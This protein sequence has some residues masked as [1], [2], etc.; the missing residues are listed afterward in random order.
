MTEADAMHFIASAKSTDQLYSRSLPDAPIHY[1]VG[2][3]GAGG[4]GLVINGELMFETRC[5]VGPD[6]VQEDAQNCRQNH[7]PKRSGFLIAVGAN[8]GLGGSIETIATLSHQSHYHWG[9]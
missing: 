3:G 9:F 7:D 4:E 2:A 8:F 5:K 6:T 1:F